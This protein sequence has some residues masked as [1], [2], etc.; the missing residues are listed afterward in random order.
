MKRTN[1]FDGSNQLF[2]NKRIRR[3]IPIFNITRNDIISTTNILGRDT[4]PV[5]LLIYDTDAKI[6]IDMTQKQNLH[7][8][9][10]SDKDSTSHKRQRL[11]DL[12][13]PIETQENVARLPSDSADEALSNERKKERQKERTREYNKKYYKNNKAKIKKQDQ[14]KYRQNKTKINAR[15]KAYREAKKESEIIAA[16][17]VL[18][19]IACTKYKE[20]QTKKSED[21]D[22]SDHFKK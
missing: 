13:L 8:E 1:S 7:I 14:E 16:A 6:I 3:N 20:L 2:F 19:Q 22:D 12:L 5:N 4:T 18:F 15:N 11:D 21:T 17:E 9:E 10:V